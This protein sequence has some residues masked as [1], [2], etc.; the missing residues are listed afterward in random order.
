MPTKPLSRFQKWVNREVRPLMLGRTMRAAVS[1]MSEEELLENWAII[2]F[3]SDVVEK[4]RNAIRAHVLEN[5]KTHG[6]PYTDKTGHFAGKVIEL[7]EHEIR[8]QR[9]MNALPEEEPMR[10]LLEKHAIDFDDAFSKVQKVVLD[11]SKVHS[12]VERGKLS[13]DEVEDTHKKSWA[14]SVKVAPTLHKYLQEL[15]SEKV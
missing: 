1:R 9:R 13:K 14:L 2:H 15:E 4:R 5:C 10:R 11:P 3:L 7:Y 6:S 8:A 12:L